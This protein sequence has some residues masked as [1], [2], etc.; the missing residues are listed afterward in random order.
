[1]DAYESQ[2]WEK[3]KACRFLVADALSRAD[4]DLDEEA[5]ERDQWGYAYV[6]LARASAELHEIIQTILRIRNRR[7]QFAGALPKKPP[8]G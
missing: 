3:I 6:Q 4:E 1:V 8:T 2:Q 5:F 7:L